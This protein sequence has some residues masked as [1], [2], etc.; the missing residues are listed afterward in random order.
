MNRVLVTG[1][2]PYG[3]VG[4]NPAAAVADALHGQEIAGHDV[5][6]AVIPVVLDGLSVRHSALVGETEPAVVVCL[7]L[8]PGE[9]AIRL[10]RYGVNLADFE[11][12]DNAGARPVDQ[13]LADGGAAAL[14]ATLPLRHILDALLRRG[15]PAHISNSAGT[16]LC[17]AALYTTLSLGGERRVP[18]GFI[19]LPYLPEQAAAAPAGTFGPPP[20]MALATMEAAVRLA[21]EVSLAT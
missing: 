11:A 6:G 12:A 17:N 21:I 15:I 1:F 20:S 13:P 7:G 14:M 5:R 2:E 10:E 4:G 8:Y 3:G 19:H 9:T 16:Y 18:T